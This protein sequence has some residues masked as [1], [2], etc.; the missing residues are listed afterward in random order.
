MAVTQIKVGQTSS[1][2]KRVPVWLVDE[3]DGITP[4]TG[5]TGQVRLSKVGGASA[6]S[7]NSLVEIDA[8]N[9][10]GSY[11]IQLTVAEVD[12]LGLIFMQF[13]DAATATW[14]DYVQIV[15]YDPYDLLVEVNAEV[16]DGLNVDQ[17]AEP[18]QDA[19]PATASLVDMVNRMYKQWRNKNVMNAAGT[20]IE[21]YNDDGST[22][23]QKRVTSEAAG[24]VTKD[25]IGSGP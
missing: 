17:Y 24:V 16:V 9:M 6:L 11:Y 23:G 8:T 19:P 12:T 1:A 2:L 4:E 13:K 3:V 21:L 10:P 20:L 22:V 14:L 18:G 15:D 7:T 25:K 5:I